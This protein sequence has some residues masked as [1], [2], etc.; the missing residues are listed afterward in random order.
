MI[1][2]QLD[3]KTECGPHLDMIH[4]VFS[5][6][7]SFIRL[8]TLDPCS[9]IRQVLPLRN[10]AQCTV[11]DDFGIFLMLADKVRVGVFS[12]WPAADDCP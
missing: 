9:A 2:W 8:L 1:W 11:L 4:N 5:F 12:S 10:V 3:A 6:S 7:T